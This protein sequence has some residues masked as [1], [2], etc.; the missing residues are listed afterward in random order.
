MTFF[1]HELFLIYKGLGDAFFS[2][3]FFLW[4]MMTVFIARHITVRTHEADGQAC[5]PR[6]PSLADSSACPVP[7]IATLVKACVGMSQS[8]WLM[9]GDCCGYTAGIE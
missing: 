2:S 5:F 6:S 3:F 8:R 9:A 7:E 4:K 1:M